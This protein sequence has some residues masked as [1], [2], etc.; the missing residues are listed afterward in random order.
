MKN[1]IRSYGAKI[2]LVYALNDAMALGALKALR[3]AGLGKVMV[4]GVDGQKEAYHEIAKGGQFKA[5]V[6]N[7]LAEITRKAV[8]LLL[9][10]L[11]SGKPSTPATVLTGT[12]LVT[13]DNV[14]RYLD[15]AST[16]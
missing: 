8:D 12:I 10:Y 3:E 16:F 13:G 15:P 9:E 4:V 7:N 11:V 6:V 14:S 1:A 5:T 2:D